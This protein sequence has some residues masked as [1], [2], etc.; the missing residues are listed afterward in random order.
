MTTLSQP[1]NVFALIFILHITCMSTAAVLKGED[2]RYDST[3]TEYSKFQAD[4]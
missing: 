2:I 3:E 1:R 4:R